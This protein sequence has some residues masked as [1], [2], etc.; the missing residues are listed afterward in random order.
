MK[1]K[2]PSIPG[3][4]TFV[5]SNVV[6]F[7]GGTTK[8]T[9]CGLTA[10]R[11]VNVFTSSEASCRECRRRWELSVRTDEGKRPRSGR[12]KVTFTD[13]ERAYLAAHVPADARIALS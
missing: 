8:E 1:S 10:T 5:L 11:Y 4:G 6:G 12:G 13:E 9:L 2:S 3:V 7:G